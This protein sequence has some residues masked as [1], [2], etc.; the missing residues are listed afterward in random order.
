MSLFSLG[1]LSII[2]LLKVGFQVKSFFNLI[3][4]KKLSIKKE[5]DSQTK[6]WKMFKFFNKAYNAY[7]L[8]EKNCFTPVTIILLYRVF[9]IYNGFED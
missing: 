8:V 3:L 5:M 4:S 7:L 9:C 6:E 2:L 1:L